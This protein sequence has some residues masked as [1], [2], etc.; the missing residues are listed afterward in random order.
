MNLFL[1]RPPRD[2]DEVGKLI[3]GAL[4]QERMDEQA[5]VAG[6]SPMG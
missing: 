6:I 5:S 2:H 3:L 4:H 1:D